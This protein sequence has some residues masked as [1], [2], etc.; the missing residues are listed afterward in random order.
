MRLA[1]DPRMIQHLVQGRTELPGEHH[2][3]CPIHPEYAK[4][5]LMQRDLPEARRLLAAAGYP[6]GIDL[7]TI[8]CIASPAW[9]FTTVQAIT[10][11]W[12]EAG[13]RVRINVLPSKQYWDIWDKTRLGFT[14]W[15]HRPLGV[16]VLGLAYR[17]GVPWNESEYANPEFDRLLTEAEGLLEVDKRRRVMAK[18]ERIMQEDGPIV[19]PLW[20]PQLTFMDKRVKG[21]KMHP[22]AF[23]FG[24]ELAIDT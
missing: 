23:I 4:L 5:P 24:N 10:E 7:G 15:A 8:D 3:V 2:H 21:F 13:M 1:I 12:K 14:A 11:Q 6:K 17:S 20:R 22:A 19:Q 16:M 18:L 9:E